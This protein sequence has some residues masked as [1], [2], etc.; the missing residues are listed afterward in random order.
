[1][2]SVGTLATEPSSS[3]EWESAE[4][5]IPGWRSAGGAT[6]PRSLI[7]QRISHSHV[8][9]LPIPDDAIGETA[10]TARETQPL[11]PPAE[12]A[13]AVASESDVDQSKAA[14]ES[15]K[16]EST[17]SAPKE[18][19]K[20]KRHS[21]PVR[22][23]PD[24]GK[25]SPVREKPDR[26][27]SSETGESKTSGPKRSKSNAK[28]P[29]K[30][31]KE[32][33][34]ESKK[35]DEAKSLAKDESKVSGPPKKSESSKS[36]SAPLE[37][38]GAKKGT[39]SDNENEGNS[40]ETEDKSDNDGTSIAAQKQPTDT[41]AEDKSSVADI[42]SEDL[43]NVAEEAVATNDGQVEAKENAVTGEKKHKKSTKKKKK[44]KKV[45]DDGSKVSNKSKKKKKK[46]RKS[47]D[48]SKE[49]KLEGGSKETKTVLGESNTPVD[50][51]TG[52]RAKKNEH[53][54]VEHDPS[55]S[56]HDA[57]NV[58]NTKKE[59]VG[60]FEQ[61][62]S[63][64]GHSSFER[65]W[66]E[67]DAPRIDK[68]SLAALD[69]DGIS[70]AD[71]ILYSAGSTSSYLAPQ[72]HTPPGSFTQPVGS[73]GRDVRRQTASLAAEET[74]RLSG[75]QLSTPT[76]RVSNH[77]QNRPSS[78]RRPD[79][80][81][82]AEQP[83]SGP[84]GAPPQRLYSG[85]DTYMEG[86]KSR[87]IL[88]EKNNRPGAFHIQG[89]GPEDD[90]DPDVLTA[91]IAMEE[92]EK[93]IEERVLKRLL[94]E[95]AKASVIRVE[96]SGNSRQFEDPIGEA[97]RRAELE[98]YRPQGLRE[99]MFGDGKATSLDIGSDPDEYIRKRDHLPWTA[100]LNC[101]TNLWVA[102]VQTNQKAW[103]SAQ[104]MYE[105]TSLE[106][107]RSIHTFVGSTEQE[108]Y[109][110]GLALAPPIMH[111]LDDNPICTM[112]KTK[113]ALLRRPCNCR[114]CGVVICSSCTCSWSG[115]QVPST[116]NLEKSSK[117][118]VCL[119]CDWL[120]SSFQE[121]LLNGDWSRTQ[122]LYN[123]GNVNLRTMY[124][125]RRKG[126]L[127]DEAMYPIHM[128]VRGGNLSLV[129][130]LLFDHYCPMYKRT[131]KDRKRTLLLTSKGRSAVDMALEQS[132]PEILKFLVSNQGVSLLEGAKKSNRNCLN[133]LM[134][135][136]E[137]IPESML[138]NISNDTGLP[139][140]ERALS[141]QSADHRPH[142]FANRGHLGSF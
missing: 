73:G 30:A 102:S 142:S 48:G 27:K 37:P 141:T 130:W 122:A 139:L 79:S 1:M 88:D 25:S 68:A 40:L 98:I 4:P 85:K 59:D 127:G 14:S 6:S 49:K 57:C 75:Q 54:I 104:Y 26:G 133:H 100:K 42:T 66:C 119:A 93:Y 58:E 20:A 71:S 116:Y 128:A 67:A 35:A 123:T 9:S 2:E 69:D 19:A 137:L 41:Q 5:V 61:N 87:S 56:V 86:V 62:P 3:T 110:I 83:V 81:D 84:V 45:S 78:I 76:V 50:T 134:C 10:E 97:E 107:K 12:T 131:G 51:C 44:K 29:A 138:S 65:A 31:K 125:A 23:K 18:P 112:C 115:K 33:S 91:N 120:A 118:T 72:H 13:Q 28:Q 36:K 80:D 7:P 32:T 53:K 55:R 124:G 114:N 21:S 94:Q 52:E 96:H 132:K 77:R 108:A 82:G 43:N 90:V 11:S 89:M 109:E 60:I 103:E 117:V 74:R 111:S 113:F 64:S 106:L 105:R 92:D 46:K 129:K 121:A 39:S 38:A 135:L 22:E 16:S 15:K 63:S 70:Y 8:A 101:T 24:R 140:Q 126:T 136:I 17:T 47:G 34:S 95:S 99:K